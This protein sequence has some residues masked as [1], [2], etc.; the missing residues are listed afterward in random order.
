VTGSGLSGFKLTDRVPYFM[1]GVEFPDCTVFGADVLSKGAEGAL[2]AGFFG[3]D[4]SVG[5]GEFAWRD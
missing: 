1:S 3:L 2:A 4:W 5:N